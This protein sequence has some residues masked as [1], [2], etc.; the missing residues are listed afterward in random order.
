MRISVLAVLRTR[1]GVS[2]PHLSGFGEVDVALLG[3]GAD[4]LYTQ[5]VAH[6][7]ALLALHQHSFYVWLENADKRALS[8]CTG[9]D[10]VEHFA[11]ATAHCD[12]GGA[13]GH[14]AL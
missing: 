3:V 4:Q 12:G 2:A 10:G 1:T 7:H 14:F 8:V 13:F 5:V 6:V 11:D 9:D